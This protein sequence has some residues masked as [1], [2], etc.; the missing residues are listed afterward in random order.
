MI[1]E[2]ERQCSNKRKKGEK[3]QI[4]LSWDNYIYINFLGT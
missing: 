4:P 3:K 1:Q 2:E